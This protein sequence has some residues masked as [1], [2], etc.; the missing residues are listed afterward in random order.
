VTGT[1]QLPDVRQLFGKVGWQR[2]GR[3]LN[4][5]VAQANNSLTG[6]AVQDFQL[7]EGGAGTVLS[8]GCHGKHGTG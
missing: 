5:S 3:E 2:E 6:N 1:T 4:L 7:L 8:H